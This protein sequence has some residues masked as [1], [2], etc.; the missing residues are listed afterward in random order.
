MRYQP[1]ITLTNDVLDRLREGTLI[2]P[3]GQWV[4]TEWSTHPSRW[5][6]TKRSGVLWASHYSGGDRQQR[7]QFQAMA[8]IRR[9]DP[10]AFYT[11]PLP[12]V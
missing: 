3:V 9:A 1:T 12:S 2:L 6:G 4:R 8:A 10:S 11:T 5:V 7:E